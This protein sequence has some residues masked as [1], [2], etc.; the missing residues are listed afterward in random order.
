MIRV[1]YLTRN[2]NEVIGCCTRAPMIVIVASL[3]LALSG[4]G[5]TPDEHAKHHP[6]PSTTDPA[7]ATPKSA[8][9]AGMAGMGGNEPTTT[10]A[11]GMAAG[12]GEMM[13]QMG[14]PPRKELYPSLMALPNEIKQEHRA[15]I[16]Q[17]AQERM[18]SGAA[19]LANGLQRLTVSS[20]GEDYN[21]MQQAAA[22]MREGLAEFESGIAAR[23]VLA[24]GK[25][26]RNLALDWFKREMNLLSPGLI[27][28]PR[29]ILGVTPFHLFT[30]ALL[31]SFAL[32]MV[33]L[34]FFKMRRAA[35]LFGR[36]DP[37]AGPPTETSEP[38]VPVKP[39]S[40]GSTA[41]PI[42]GR[43]TTGS[44]RQAPSSSV[45]PKES[46]K[47]ADGPLISRGSSAS[48]V[49]ANWKGRL[50]IG[51]IVQETSVIKTFRLFSP[52]PNQEIPFIFVPGQFLNVTFWIGG[53]KMNRSYSISSS[54][55]QRQYVELT[56]RREPR[57][58]VSRHVFD[59]L[60]VGD[61]IDAA[62]PVGKFTFTGTESDSVVLISAGVGITPMMSIARYLTERS[63]P[64][65]VYFVFTCHS[66]SDFIFA[67]ELAV[68]AK[69]NPLLHLLVTISKPEGLEWN[70]PR[71][72]I[73]KEWLA[74]SVP[75]LTSRRVHLCGPP[76]MME[77]TRAFLAEL[78]LPPEQLK[79]EAFGAVKPAPPAADAKSIAISPATGPLVTFSKSNKSAKIRV[80]LKSGDSP[81]RQSILELSEELGIGIEFSCRI[82]TCGICKVKM[83]SGDVEMDVTDA[84]DDEDRSEN[85][86][87]ACQAKPIGEVAVE[88]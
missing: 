8:L 84:L 58:A 63:W 36:I 74:S 50:R 66:Q 13:K 6:A 41:A 31:V 45:P 43:H 57:G 64:G 86:I 38:V 82:G 26:P 53:A 73:T 88:A 70:G 48:P 59:L 62:G 79:T 9:P 68:L 67:N 35:A 47:G 52:T 11:G 75:D 40:D 87:L 76:P 65:E 49:A 56:I 14:V 10:P 34:Y 20:S 5:Q 21:A 28:Q 78:G 19:R 22:Q 25:A 42:P 12:M 33:A 7:T 61:E 77:S 2:S 24:E 30:M 51:S 81:P 27:D 4:A 69:R 71:G 37:D 32:A 85:V 46:A 17:L 72:R 23:R 44:P 54:P 15:A 55:T 1:H 83:I 16:E 3:T 60:K 39:S 29:T 80:D 18:K